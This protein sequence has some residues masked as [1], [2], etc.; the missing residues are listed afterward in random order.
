[1]LVYDAI[2]PAPRCSR[3]FL[4]EKLAARPATT[5]DVFAGDNRQPAYLAV[6]P[7]GQTPALLCDDDLI[8]TGRA[9]RSPR[10]PQ[11]GCGRV[12]YDRLAWLDGMFTASPYLCGEC[13]AV[14]PGA[15]QSRSLLSSV[16]QAPHAQA[17]ARTSMTL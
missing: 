12:A 13:F 8:I 15:E 5:V 9:S 17:C 3:M 16:D 11:T 7:T 1:M 2:S 4:L 14:R 6:N 10:K